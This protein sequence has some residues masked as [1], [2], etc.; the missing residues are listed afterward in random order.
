LEYG[1][2]RSG[3]VTIAG[4]DYIPPPAKLLPKLFDKMVV[5]ASKILDIYDQ[6]IH[7]FLTMARTQF[8]Y[9]VNK[10][11]GRFVMNVF[12]LNNGYPAINLPAKKQL[13]FNQLMLIFYKTGNQ[14]LMNNFLRSCLDDK[15]IKI[16][17]EK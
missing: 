8:F 11:M 17:K 3:G 15:I 6:A 16:M 12:L 13:E 10:R 2:F 9:D 14:S 4:T 7:F 5:D 1:A